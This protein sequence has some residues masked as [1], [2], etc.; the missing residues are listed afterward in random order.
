[1]RGGRGVGGIIQKVFIAMIL[2]GVVLAIISIFNDD[3]FAVLSWILSQCWQFILWVRDFLTG[4]TTF[5]SLF[6]R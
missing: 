4:Q 1:M 2:I 5:R 3:V 6:E